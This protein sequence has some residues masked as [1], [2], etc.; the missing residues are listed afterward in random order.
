M[1]SLYNSVKD[2]AQSD[3]IIAPNTLSEQGTKSPDCFK[4]SQ[5]GAFYQ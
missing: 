5:L 4:G 2:T 3:H 1:H